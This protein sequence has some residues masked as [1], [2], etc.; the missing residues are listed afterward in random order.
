M[1]ICKKND[2]MIMHVLITKYKNIVLKYV[3]LVG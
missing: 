3:H 2:N 1:Y